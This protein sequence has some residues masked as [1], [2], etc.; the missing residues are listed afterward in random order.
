[1]YVIIV[2]TFNISLIISLLITY[3]KLL[4]NYND[5]INIELYSIIIT[6]IIIP[7]ILEIIGDLKNK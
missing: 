1:M 7:I 2:K 6:A 4:I 3:Y 5:S